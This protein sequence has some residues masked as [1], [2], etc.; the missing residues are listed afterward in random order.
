MTQAQKK[1]I[2]HLWR[3]N[4]D[5]TK[6]LDEFIARFRPGVGSTA[7]QNKPGDY[8]GGGWCGM[9]VGIETDGHTHT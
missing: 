1:A 9:Y 6:N 8:V 7:E 5:G 4:R 3:Q 2:F